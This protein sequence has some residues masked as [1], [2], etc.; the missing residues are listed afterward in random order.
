VACSLARNLESCESSSEAVQVVLS[1]VALHFKPRLPGLTKLMSRFSK[2]NNW[3]KALHIFESLHLCGITA[4][5]TIANA[6]IAACDKGGDWLRAKK[7]FDDMERTSLFR[8]TITFSSTISALSKSKQ[9]RQ[10]IEVCA[11]AGCA[12][13][14]TLLIA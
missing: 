9:P 2:S 3:H 1:N 12:Y 7:I 14:H 13:L 5:T 6:A 10:S 11:C 4:D 8:D